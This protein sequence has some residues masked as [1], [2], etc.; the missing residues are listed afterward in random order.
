MKTIHFCLLFFGVAT[1]TLAAT[2]QTIDIINNTSTTLHIAHDIP[3]HSKAHIEITK[4]NDLYAA[5]LS[6]SAEKIKNAV[7]AGANVNQIKSGK[8]LLFWA[9]SSNRRNAIETL[10]QLGAKFDDEC[11]QKILKMKDLR[12]LLLLVKQGLIKLDVREITGVIIE[13]AG[14]PNTISELSNIAFELIK[15]LVNRG[16]NTNDVWEAAIILAHFQESKGY[17][18]IRF[19]LFRGANPNYLR[20]IKNHGLDMV[21]TP[22]SMVLQWPNKKV[23][24]LLL[25]A[26]A[27]LNNKIRPYGFKKDSCTTV[28]EWAIS[29]DTIP[30]FALLGEERS[31]TGGCKHNSQLLRQEIVTLLLQTCH[32]NTP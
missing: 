4:I 32:A 23:A 12:S 28:L 5:I 2:K 9:I 16:Y 10:I 20:V 29:Q 19:L 3:E 18:L 1:S 6:D 14:L 7:L 22:F 31:R 27:D 26:G 25:K 15:E 17:D 21:D 13:N 11:S 30:S 24:E 8:A